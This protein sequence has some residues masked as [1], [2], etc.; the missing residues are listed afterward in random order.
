VSVGGLVAGVALV[1]ACG[2][3]GYTPSSGPGRQ[4]PG[5]E[6]VFVRPFENHTSDAESGALLG[7]A[8]RRELARRDAD[9]GREARA[10]IEGEIVQAY[11][12]PFSPN[13]AIYRFTLVVA[14]R[15]V[16]D[17]RL[18]VQQSFAR[19]EDLLAGQ[20]PLES[21][22]RRRLALR[23]ASDAIAREIVERF[24]QP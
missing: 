24:E 19:N 22:G 10:R 16:V 17:D 9:A 15:L 1:L 18:V 12:G 7:A 2:G 5:A 11:F 13:G 4:R 20:D 14:A 8:L 6:R 23:R 21:E 3:C